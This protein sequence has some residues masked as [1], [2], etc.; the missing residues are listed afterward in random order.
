M[1]PKKCVSALIYRQDDEWELVPAPLLGRQIKTHVPENLHR[2]WDRLAGGFQLPAHEEEAR[3]AAL[4][5][6]QNGPGIGARIPIVV[7]RSRALGAEDYY[8]RLAGEGLTELELFNAQGN[9]FDQDAARWRIQEPVMMFLAGGVLTP[10]RLLPPRQAA[11]RF[12]KLRDSLAAKPD[13]RPH[14]VAAPGPDGLSDDYVTQL[15]R[16]RK[17]AGRN[18][19]P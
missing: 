6:A 7:E 5:L 2:S 9:S 4:W 18:D 14:L 13:L 11:E 15:Q 12:V 10:P 8:K 1:S 3:P 17:A 16:P 19:G